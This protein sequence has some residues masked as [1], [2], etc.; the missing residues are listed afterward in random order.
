[1]VK[2][3]RDLPA[4][5]PAERIALDAIELAVE[6]RSPYPDRAT[7]LDADEPEVGKWIRRA[8]D[9]GRAVVLVTK[10]G[11]TRILRGEPASA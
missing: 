10:D 2:D 4:R 6:G 7:F 1:M 5:S 8:V 11:S 9:D 3:L